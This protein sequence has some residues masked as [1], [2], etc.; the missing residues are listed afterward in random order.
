MTCYVVNDPEQ[1]P[2]AKWFSKDRPSTFTM[3]A[4]LIQTRDIKNLAQKR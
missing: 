2:F 3:T 4:K 1:D